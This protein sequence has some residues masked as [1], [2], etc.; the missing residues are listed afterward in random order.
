MASVREQEPAASPG[1]LRGALFRR[2]YG[3][4][5]TAEAGDR[6][7]SWLRGSAS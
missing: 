5:F 1:R 3:K 4:D 7:A 6:I 2:L